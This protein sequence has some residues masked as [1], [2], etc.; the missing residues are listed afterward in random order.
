LIEQ[1]KKIAQELRRDRCG[2]R[3]T[4]PALQEL[5]RREGLE[6]GPAHFGFNWVDW[7]ARSF[8]VL[9]NNPAPSAA[10]LCSP[11]R[12]GDR[13]RFG[14]LVGFFF[15]LSFSGGRPRLRFFGSAI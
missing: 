5:V 3:L 6:H 13:H 2:V 14:F 15:F 1:I 8:D 10:C 4:E 11:Y 7:P 9:G 12:R